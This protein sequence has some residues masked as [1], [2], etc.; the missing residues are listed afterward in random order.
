MVKPNSR[1]HLSK[2]AH[3]TVTSEHHPY[4]YIMH[5]TFQLCSHII[6]DQRQSTSTHRSSISTR[7]PHQH[8]THIYVLPIPSNIQGSF[9]IHVKI[10]SPYSKYIIHFNISYKSKDKLC[11]CVTLFIS[12]HPSPLLDTHSYQ[13]SST[14]MYIIHIG[15]SVMLVHYPRHMLVVDVTHNAQNV[16]S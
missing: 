6:Q 16:H 10:S 15:V 1:S 14:F 5:L 7:Y 3:H 12:T 13:G 4:S 2:S 9:I 8:I 11:K